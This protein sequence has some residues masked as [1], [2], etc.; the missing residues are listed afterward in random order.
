MAVVC[1]ETVERGRRQGA[2]RPLGMQE[3]G[4]AQEQSVRECGVEMGDRA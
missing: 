1:E 3:E 2:V 4:A